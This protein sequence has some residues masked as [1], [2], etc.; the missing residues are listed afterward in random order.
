[1]RISFDLEQ[2]LELHVEHVADLCVHLAQNVVV[3]IGTETLEVL[4][5]LHYL[6]SLLIIAFLFK[7]MH[8]GNRTLNYFLDARLLLRVE[9]RVKVHVEQLPHV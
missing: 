1:M 7:M 9:D 5:N 6:Q 4:V 8:T 2:L 3:F